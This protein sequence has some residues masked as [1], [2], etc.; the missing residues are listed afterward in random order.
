MY[1]A[2]VLNKPLSLHSNNT[3]LHNYVVKLCTSTPLV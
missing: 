3:K 2:I 1:Y